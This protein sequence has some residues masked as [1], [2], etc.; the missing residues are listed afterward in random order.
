L[1]FS[2]RS[3]D[4]VRSAWRRLLR[5]LTGPKL[6]VHSDLHETKQN[7]SEEADRILAKIHETGQDSLTSRER[8]FLERYSREVRAK[9][10]LE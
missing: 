8:K 7:D 6:K 4:D 10:R 9:Q 5:R 2:F 1:G 3:L